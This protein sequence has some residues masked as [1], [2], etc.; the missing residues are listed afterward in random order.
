M[1][2][3]DQ[4]FWAER[5]EW[6]LVEESRRKIFLH[7]HGAQHPLFAEA[8]ATDPSPSVGRQEKSPLKRRA[9]RLTFRAGFHLGR[10]L[11]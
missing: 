1:S 2:D 4:E 9:L 3:K 10:W 8:P 7:D 11:R 5:Y 6:F